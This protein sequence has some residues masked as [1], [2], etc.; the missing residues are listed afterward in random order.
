M[1]RESLVDELRRK[2]SEGKIAGKNVGFEE[3]TLARILKARNNPSPIRKPLPK[4]P[5]S[6]SDSDSDR[7]P[8]VLKVTPLKLEGRTVDTVMV[9][10]IQHAYITG[11]NDYLGIVKGK[12]LVKDPKHPDPLQEYEVDD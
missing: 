6:D 5:P 8:I 3:R 11:T 2:I 7:S 12:S 9:E 4:Q 10:G 1:N